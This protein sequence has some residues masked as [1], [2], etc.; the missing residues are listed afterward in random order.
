[1]ANSGFQTE[2]GAL[3]PLLRQRT[4]TNLE[5]R[6]LWKFLQ[7]Q[8]YN[9]S[10]FFSDAL[11]CHC[12]FSPS[13]WNYWLIGWPSSPFWLLF[14]FFTRNQPLIVRGMCL[15]N[16]IIRWFFSFPPSLVGLEANSYFT[17]S[18][19]HDWFHQSGE[20]YLWRK[21]WSKNGPEG[22]RGG[23]T[24]HLLG[25]WYLGHLGNPSGFACA[26]KGRVFP[27]AST[28]A[29][30]GVRGSSDFTL[31][32]KCQLH[33]L[34]TVSDPAVMESKSSGSNQQ[35]KE[36]QTG[37]IRKAWNY[38]LFRKLQTF[39]SFPSLWKGVSVS[40]INKNKIWTKKIKLHWR[41]LRGAHGGVPRCP[42]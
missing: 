11:Q 32:P 25:G 3:Q 24:L 5:P 31:I 10:S 40:P 20:T 12:R 1:M 18:W 14:S 42:F 27:E 23:G 34:Q 6:G 16:L 21:F 13:F 33:R 2:P 29:A 9:S 38:S 7:R 39:V 30:T 19:K 8:T 26:P 41:S 22:P 36:V 37:S 28:S 35:D 4:C 15:N 17:W